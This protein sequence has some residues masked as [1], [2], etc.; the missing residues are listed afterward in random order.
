MRLCFFKFVKSDFLAKRS[1][2]V[3]VEEFFDNMVGIDDDKGGSN[4]SKYF[5]APIPAHNITEDLGFI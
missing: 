2:D 5:I 4:T 1:E 3:R